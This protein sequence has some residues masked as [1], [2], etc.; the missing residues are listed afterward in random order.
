M[1]NKF[2]DRKSL[3]ETEAEIAKEAADLEAK[4][5]VFES[6]KKYES[7]LA[8]YE[9]RFNVEPEE[10]PKTNDANGFLIILVII[11]FVIVISFLFFVLK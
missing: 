6:R 2:N 7:D 11:V 8:E 9:A 4:I 5:K 3:E 1:V 10:T